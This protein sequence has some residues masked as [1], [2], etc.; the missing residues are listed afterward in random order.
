[1]SQQ[2]QHLLPHR[3]RGGQLHLPASWSGVGRQVGTLLKRQPLVTAGVLLGASFAL[4]LAY[5]QAIATRRHAHE[6]RRVMR[7]VK[8]NFAGRRVEILQFLFESSSNRFDLPQ[9]E[10][11]FAS[12]QKLL[13]DPR[14][15]LVPLSDL[16]QLYKAGGVS[17][18]R[19]ALSCARFW[20]DGNGQV[21]FLELVDRLNLLVFGS[22]E[23]HLRAFFRVF[24]LDASG[25]ISREEVEEVV[26]AMSAVPH[27]GHGVAALSP[28][29]RAAQ[30]REHP[31]VQAIFQAADTHHNGLIHEAEFLRLAEVETLTFAFN[32][33]FVR[34]FGID[35][36]DA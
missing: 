5:R 17:D 11:I 13:T 25:V 26:R 2:P 20:D 31:L 12:F 16:A 34:A 33:D 35:W 36:P 23:A 30:H 22:R 7:L 1:M 3:P 24:D 9:L 14:R 29:T 28:K 19:V 4:L 32:K 18:E 6:R 15:G 21:D 10:A 8:T 27:A